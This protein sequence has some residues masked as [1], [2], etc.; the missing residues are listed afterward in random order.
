MMTDE[1]SELHIRPYRPAD[2]QA[3]RQICLKT[4]YR[5]RGYRLFFE[6]GELFADY[7]TGYYLDYNPELSFVAEREGEVVG[8]LLGCGD[9][10]HFLK[11]MKRQI[12]PG[13]VF[14]LAWRILRLRYRRLKTFRFIGWLL[15]RSWREVPPIPLDRFPAHY[16]LNLLPGGRFKHGFSALLLRFLDELE[17]RGVP[18]LYGIVL[19]PKKGGIISKMF[20]AVAAVGLKEEYFRECPTTM[21]RSVLK[22]DTPMVNR[23]YA[24]NL[25][26]YRRFVE[27]AAARYNL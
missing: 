26:I 11:V 1:K 20:R 3:V 9:S 12:L 4:A 21:Y 2:R 7:W 22:D 25:T 23:I 19:E 5:N 10:H 15:W 13:I 8:Y 16:H 18:G 27:Y 17:R 14:K 24:S 6:D